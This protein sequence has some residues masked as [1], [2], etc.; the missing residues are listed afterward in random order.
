MRPR[1]SLALLAALSATAALVLAGC[2]DQVPSMFRAESTQA[3][4]IRRLAF[5][6]FAI[7]AGVLLT[8]WI[9]LLLAI[10]RYRKRPESA[11]KQ[12]HGS[13]RIE[14]I[15]TLIPAIIVAVLFYLTIQTTGA[16]TATV[17][18]QVDMKVTAYQWW[19]AIEYPSGEFVTANEIHVPVD[20][21]VT[22]DLVSVDVIHSFWVPQM[23]GKLDMIPGHVNTLHFVPTTIGRYI[24][25]CS[26]YCG[27]Q[28]GRMR[29][30]L[31]VDSVEDFTAWFANERRPARA[32]QGALATAGA[33]TIT[34]LPCVGCHTIRGNE[35]MRGV[36]GP[37]LTHVG[38]RST[39]AAVTITNTPA[40]MRR[41]LQD[42]QQVKPEN[43]MPA[44]PL[45]SQQL[46][47][48]VAYMEGLK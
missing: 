28:H 4:D 6:I 24:G 2:S 19:W 47:E 40:N 22:A 26:E 25:A 17:P 20:K 15:W 32:P 9:W 8:V 27:H 18:V 5:M 42:P 44:V 48:L 29:F 34:R 45:T 13:L 1:G 39:L 21:T 41:W 16:L 33:Q 43:L 31:Y 38:S 3:D 10:V 37:D 46:D 11:V 7:L 14:L 36:S 12:T 35:A 23:G 30:L